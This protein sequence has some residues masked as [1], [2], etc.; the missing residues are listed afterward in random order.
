M[1][2]NP[3]I[4]IFDWG[5]APNPKKAKWLILKATNRQGSILAIV[6]PAYSRPIIAQNPIPSIIRIN[7]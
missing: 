1:Y 7:L 4:F 6:V 2:Q 5:F 3:C